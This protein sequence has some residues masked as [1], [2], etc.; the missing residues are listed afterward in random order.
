LMRCVRNAHGGIRAVIMPSSCLW[1]DRRVGSRDDAWAEAGSN[2]SHRKLLISFVLS[3]L[4]VW[5]GGARL[6][7][8]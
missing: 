7:K 3:F 1:A 2:S 4:S 5:E 6:R 8:L